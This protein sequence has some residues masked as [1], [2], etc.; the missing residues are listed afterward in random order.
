MA[1]LLAEEEHEIESSY[2][3][4]HVVPVKILSNHNGNHFFAALGHV[5]QLP[6]AHLAAERILAQAE[7]ADICPFDTGLPGF[8]MSLG[9]LY[10]SERSQT[11]MLSHQSTPLG[12]SC[13]ARSS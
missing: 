3:G 4:P 11:L 9:C 13:T 2:V 10:I 1:H 5:I 12:M 8:R 7:Y 6:T